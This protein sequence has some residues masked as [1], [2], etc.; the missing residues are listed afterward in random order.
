MFGEVSVIER[1]LAS[2]RRIWQ[3][4]FRVTLP[5]GRI[6]RERRKARGATC[7]AAAR[8]IG[9]RRLQ[10][11]PPYVTSLLAGPRRKGDVHA[12]QTIGPQRKTAR[13]TVISRGDSQWQNNLTCDGIS[14]ASP[15]FRSHCATIFRSPLVHC[16]EARKISKPWK[17][18]AMN[19]MRNWAACLAAE[20]GFRERAHARKLSGSQGST[21][22]PASRN[23]GNSVARCPAYRKTLG[24]FWTS[25]AFLRRES[26]NRGC[27]ATVVRRR[28]P[29][30]VQPPR[31]ARQ[32]FW[33]GHLNLAA[34]AKNS[35]CGSDFAPREGA[36]A[37][38]CLAGEQRALL[39][40]ARIR[41]GAFSNSADAAH[42]LEVGGPS[43]RRWPAPRGGAGK[44]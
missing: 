35:T 14:S 11:R 42:D 33:K 15:V 40:C 12:V 13:A 38:G 31:H 1:V 32:S 5:D 6:Y 27:C 20:P 23:D 43:V 21:G 29:V 19:A 18:P 28:W 7:E 9:R 4:D 8:Q 39:H 26:E 25:V 22:A 36:P 10:S 3:Y 44:N 41:A 17:P 2:G 24:L 37:A 30:E 34:K 16:L